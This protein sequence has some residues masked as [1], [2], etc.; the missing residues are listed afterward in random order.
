MWVPA[1]AKCAYR[2]AFSMFGVPLPTAVH[3]M[4]LCSAG[5]SATAMKDMLKVSDKTV[6]QWVGYCRDVC[7]EEMQRCP[8]V[9]RPVHIAL[10]ILFMSNFVFLHWRCWSHR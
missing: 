8:P 9:V 1:R 4:Y 7:D 10:Y 5:V 3:V 2:L 6:T